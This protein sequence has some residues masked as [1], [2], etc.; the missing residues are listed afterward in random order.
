MTGIKLYGYAIDSET[1]NGVDFDGKELST[2]EM[3]SFLETDLTWNG[4]DLDEDECDWCI[5][6]GGEVHEFDTHRELKS[7]FKGWILSRKML[8][9]FCDDSKM[10]PSMPK[11]PHPPIRRKN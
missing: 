8:V 3:E 11:E 9:G 7:F 1:G 4:L 5:E 2:E 10:E 6:V